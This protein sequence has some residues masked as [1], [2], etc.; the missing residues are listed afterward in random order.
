MDGSI[1]DMSGSTYCLD[2]P[3]CG[4][5]TVQV[6]IFKCH[7]GSTSHCANSKN[8]EWKVNTNGSITSKLNI[9]CLNVHNFDGPAVETYNCNGQTN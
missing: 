6:E 9:K 2:I 7:I 8:Q 1:T 3:Q 4:N 5:G